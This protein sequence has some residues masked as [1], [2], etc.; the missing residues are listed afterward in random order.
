MIITLEKAKANNNLSQNTEM[1]KKSLPT[2]KQKN[3]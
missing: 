2:V 1:K 3:E